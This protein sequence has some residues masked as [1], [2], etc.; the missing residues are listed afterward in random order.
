MDRRRHWGMN[1]LDTALTL[2]FLVRLDKSGMGCRQLIEHT[3][4][5]R[6]KLSLLVLKISI[7]L[8]GSLLAGFGVDT[9][10]LCLTAFSLHPIGLSL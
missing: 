6:L 9:F 7:V 2:H 5:L 1:D 8:F 4:E 10:F 3:S